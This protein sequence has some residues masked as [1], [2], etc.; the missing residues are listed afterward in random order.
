M[1]SRGKIMTSRGKRNRETR[2]RWRYSTT[3][4][5]HQLSL[6]EHA[7]GQRNSPQT[8]D[9]VPGGE[10]SGHFLSVGASGE[11]VSAGTK[12]RR[13]STEADRNSSACPPGEVNFFIER[14]RCRVGWWEFP[15]RLFRYFD[16]RCSA[17]GQIS[18]CDFMGYCRSFCAYPGT[19]IYEG[20]LTSFI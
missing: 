1:T 5:T 3:A 14:S 18:R 16:R 2:L 17:G 8:D 9:L 15:A 6:P 11:S 19:D 13:Y 12:V 20:S 4:T 7:I 10:A